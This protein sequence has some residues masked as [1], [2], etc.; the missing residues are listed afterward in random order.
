MDE[1][2]NRVSAPLTLRRSATRH[3]GPPTVETANELLRSRSARQGRAAVFLKRVHPPIVELHGEVHS[4][5]AI[6]GLELD[7]CAAGNQDKS[8]DLALSAVP[9]AAPREFDA[10]SVE[11]PWP[12]PQGGRNQSKRVTVGGA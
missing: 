5:F 7:D 8:G 10:K 11:I 4:D 1:G 12:P 2:A 3:S 6:P 9:E